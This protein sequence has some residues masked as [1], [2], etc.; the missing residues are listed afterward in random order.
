MPASPVS[1]TL[2]LSGLDDAAAVAVLNA[3]VGSAAD[4]S[5]AAHV[6]GGQTAVRLEG[7]AGSVAARAA[8]VRA[9]WSATG[10]IVAMTGEDEARF[11]TAIA[12]VSPI[13]DARHPVWRIVVPPA[14][15]PGVVAG[16]GWRCGL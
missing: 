5:A 4:V 9:S 10:S 15:S 1:L 12:T 7:F 11:W 16:A 6:A 2:A 3:A 8:T 13:A 14:A